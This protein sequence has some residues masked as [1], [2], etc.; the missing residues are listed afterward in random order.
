MNQELKS[1]TY[2]WMQQFS[3]VVAE[4][5]AMGAAVVLA[6][7]AGSGKSH[8]LT[9]E[10]NVPDEQGVFPRLIR[11]QAQPSVISHLHYLVDE[12]TPWT[13]PKDWRMYSM[14]A[15]IKLLARRLRHNNVSQILL[16]GCERVDHQFYDAIFDVMRESRSHGHRW[17]LV[18]AGRGKLSEFELQTTYHRSSIRQYVQ[19]PELVGGDVLS[20]MEQWCVGGKE[21]AERSEAG[22]EEAVDMTEEILKGNGANI[23]MLRLWAE[24]KNTHFPESAFTPKLVADVF[25]A[26]RS[27][28]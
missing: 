2:P 8:I 13:L 9:M 12:I 10:S 26:L 21:L 5:K 1:I 14:G 20:A 25:G 15:M 11:M 3:Q 16:T 18:L 28:Q 23:G 22:V 19:V 6:G 7:A 27:T 24:I 4:S 17:G